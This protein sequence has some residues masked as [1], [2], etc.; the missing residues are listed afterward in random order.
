[1]QALSRITRRYRMQ[2]KYCE[3]PYRRQIPRLPQRLYSDPNR[4]GHSFFLPLN[5]PK[6]NGHVLA[7]SGVG[8]PTSAMI[9]GRLDS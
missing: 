8:L 4:K 5:Q 1:M 7:T 9:L 3:D 2:D 6:K